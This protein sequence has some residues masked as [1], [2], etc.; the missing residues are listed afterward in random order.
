MPIRPQDESFLPQLHRYRDSGVNVVTL[1]ICW[2]GMPPSVA[3][4]MAATIR[5]WVA[6]ATE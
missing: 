5:N 2:D 6:V 1:N 3:V 4:P